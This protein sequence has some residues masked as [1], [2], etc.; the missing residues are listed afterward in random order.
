MYPLSVLFE[1]FQN[2]T[3]HRGGQYRVCYCEFYGENCWAV[4]F[5]QEAGIL[6]VHGPKDGHAVE[7]VYRTPSVRGAPRPNRSSDALGSV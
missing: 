5:K 1:V 6:T 4:F 2:L 7:A 3:I